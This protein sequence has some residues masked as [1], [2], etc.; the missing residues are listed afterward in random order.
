MSEDI[1]RTHQEKRNLGRGLAALLG[2]SEGDYGASEKGRGPR[3]LAVSLL[4]PGPVQPRHN[5]DEESLQVSI[6][7]ELEY[8]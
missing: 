8:E 7:N 4:K 5:F 2:E 3:T 1:P 6:N